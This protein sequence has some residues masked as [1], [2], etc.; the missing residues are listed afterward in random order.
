MLSAI[1]PAA[2]ESSSEFP[3]SRLAV[4]IVGYAQLAAPSGPVTHLLWSIA[5]HA[6]Y[7]RSRPSGHLGSSTIDVAFPHPATGQTS[8]RPA[9][10]CRRRRGETDEKAKPCETG[11]K[12][13]AR[14]QKR[15]RAK[16]GPRKPQR[17]AQGPKNPRRTKG[18]EGGPKGQ[19]GEKKRRRTHVQ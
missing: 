18:E 6:I 15:Q 16:K 10:C 7:I 9:R 5:M 14:A 2:T 1:A 11:K 17:R 4:Q 3:I 12:K 13:R 19:K 8:C